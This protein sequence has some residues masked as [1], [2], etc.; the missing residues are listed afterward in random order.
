MSLR[1]IYS[2]KYEPFFDIKNGK[3]IN[4]ISISENP[5]GILNTQVKR[6]KK[7]T[8]SEKEVVG[9]DETCLFTIMSLKD[10]E[11]FMTINELPILYAFLKNNNYI[12]NHIDLKWENKSVCFIE[13]YI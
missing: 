11:K 2:V 3:Y 10:K 13:Y 6:V 8:L 5:K 4:I 12:I 7:E 1:E 9:K